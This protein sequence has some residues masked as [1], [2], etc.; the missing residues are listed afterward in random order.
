M[1]KYF[2]YAATAPVNKSVIQE[3]LEI[4][5]KDFLFGNP[6]S[7]HVNGINA[8]I[9][10]NNARIKIANLL[11]CDKEEII[12]TSGGTE[13]DNMALFG[14]MTKYNPNEAEMITSSIEHPAIIN[15]AKIIQKMGYKVHYISP[16]KDG[17]IRAEDVSKKINNKTKLISIMAVNNE[18]GTIQP[19]NEIYQICKQNNIIFHSDMVQ[20]VGFTDLN[21]ENV[22][23]ASFSAHKF[24]GLKGTGFLFKRKN[25][26]INPFINGGGQEN[27]YRSGTENVF[28]NLVMAYCLEDIIKKNNSA[29]I[30][31]VRE[32]SKFL[33]E[34]LKHEFQDNIILNGSLEKR[35]SNNINISFRNINSET[36][37]LMLSNEGYC[38]S[39]G[40]ACHS[41]KNENSYV[42]EEINVPEEYIKGTLRITFST[43][44]T[45]QDVINLLNSIIKNVKILYKEGVN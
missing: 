40:S 34:N 15:T 44:I 36:L 33:Y 39:I 1:N 30:N 10:L 38:V 9:L 26:Q 16:N 11:K 6:S 7:I 25:L 12:F 3:I 4:Y 13:S 2:D 20:N 17:I 5:D 18:I 24:G 21:M 14:V 28:G 37:Q 42:L 29:K 41:N 31:D 23:L 45:K 32:Y 27:S 22:D 8:K 19:L 35:V 43:N